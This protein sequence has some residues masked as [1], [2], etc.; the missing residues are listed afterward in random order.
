M[1]SRIKLDVQT[2]PD[3]AG[4]WR[5]V[6]QRVAPAPGLILLELSPGQVF[7]VGDVGTAPLLRLE[8]SAPFRGYLRL[9]TGEGGGMRHIELVGG[10]ER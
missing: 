9:T 6:K 7:E 2:N 8:P 10:V 5:V 1:A 3:T 4:E